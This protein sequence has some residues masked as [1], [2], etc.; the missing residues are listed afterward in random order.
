MIRR[1][2]VDYGGDI[3]DGGG[4]GV[5]GNDIGNGDDFEVLRT[6][7]RGGFGLGADGCTHVVALELVSLEGFEGGTFSRR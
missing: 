3:F 2:A 1:S 4:V 7:E 5:G 6:R